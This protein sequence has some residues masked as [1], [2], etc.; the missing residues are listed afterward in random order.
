MKPYEVVGVQFDSASVSL[1]SPRASLDPSVKKTLRDRIDEL[2]RQSAALRWPAA[3]ATLKNPSFEKGDADTKFA[4]WQST[5]VGA[6]SLSI[7]SRLAHKDGQSAVMLSRGPV[8]SLRSDGVSP[9]TSGRVSVSVWL[10]VAD[11]SQQP[12]LRLAIEGQHRGRPYYRY[13]TVGAGQNAVL[14]KTEWSQFIFQV[15]DLPVTDLSDLRVRFDLM[16]SGEVWVDDVELFPLAFSDSERVEI[17]KLIS[18]AG[19]HLDK[20]K[21][22]QCTRVLE[23]H[24]PKF[25]ATHVPLDDSD[26]STSSDVAKRDNPNPDEQPPARTPEKTG[27]LDRVRGALPF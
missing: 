17:S 24:W 11:T 16:G 27:F 10:R 2:T 18:V 26:S 21:I 8:L 1:R 14:I 6:T 20:G 9:P 23:G 3:L 15:D 13:A 7:D 12:P 22:G 19:I 4:G 25:L 5:G